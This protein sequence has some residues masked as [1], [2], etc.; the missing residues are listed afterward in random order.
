MARAPAKTGEGEFKDPDSK[1]SIANLEHEEG[2][3]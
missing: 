1:E 3:I 2:P